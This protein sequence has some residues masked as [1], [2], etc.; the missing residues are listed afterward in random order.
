MQPP[1]TRNCSKAPI[2]RRILHALFKGL[3]AI[4]LLSIR[5]VPSRPSETFVLPAK[6]SL[7]NCRMHFAL[8][9]FLH[10]FAAQ[11]IRRCHSSVGRAQDWKSWCP[12]FDSW[13]HHCPRKR[14]CK[15]ASRFFIFGWWKRTP[16]SL[17]LEYTA[18]RIDP[19]K[20]PFLPF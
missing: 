12:R 16:T 20:H 13:W 3:P 11:K 10:R 18:I 5:S 8:Q 17:L 7:N 14:E 4:N 2:H 6:E 1:I 15:N 9:H 19:K